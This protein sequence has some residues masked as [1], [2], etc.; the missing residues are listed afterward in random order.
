MQD[1]TGTPIRYYRWLNGS[2][3][4]AGS[5]NYEVRELIDLKIPPMVARNY[6]LPQF[7]FMKL[8]PG[9]DIAQGAALK[10][11]S[12]A[13][14]SAGPNGLFGDEI[15]PFDPPGPPPM[16]TIDS[17][18]ALLGI[19]GASGAA[20]PVARELQIRAAGVVLDKGRFRSKLPRVVKEGG[21]FC[22]SRRSQ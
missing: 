8:R 6:A 18:A 10:G 7:R 22:I 17:M 2:E 12:W 19:P 20:D 1:R 21:V 13:I 3:Y 9:R 15:T 14:V 5:R 11:A 16:F 4:P